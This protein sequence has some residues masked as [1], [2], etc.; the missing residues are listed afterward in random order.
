MKPY[1]ALLLFPRHR[2][3]YHGG[4]MLLLLCLAYRPRVEV[5]WHLPLA[6]L[7]LYSPVGSELVG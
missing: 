2:G 5:R 7:E 6:R 1:N 3:S 4:N